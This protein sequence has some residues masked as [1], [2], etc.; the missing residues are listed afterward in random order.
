MSRQQGDKKREKGLNSA[1]DEGE[2]GHAG[3]LKIPPYVGQQWQR[4]HCQ[5][6][7][8]ASRGPGQRGAGGCLLEAGLQQEEEE[9]PHKC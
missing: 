3:T 9:E 7:L 8:T 6:K 1:D 5:G 4:Q 2:R